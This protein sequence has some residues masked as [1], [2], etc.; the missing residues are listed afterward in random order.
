MK[1]GLLLLVSALFTFALSA[2]VVVFTENFESPS[3][4]DS[5]TSTTGAGGVKHWDIS[6]K[7]SVSGSNSDSARVG[8]ASTY[9]LTTD[10]FNTVGNTYVLLEF[11]QICKITFFDQAEVEVSGDSGQTWNKLTDVHYL[12]GASFAG[13]GSRFAESSYGS[14]WAPN[15]PVDPLP[16]WWKGELFDISAFAASATHAAVRFKL[17]DGGPPGP[18]NRYG[19]LIDDIKVTAALSELQP[20]N[21]ISFTPVLT[22]NIFDTGPFN[23]TAEITDA[24]GIQRAFIPYTINGIADTV[25]LVNTSGNNWSGS[26]PAVTH[27]DDVCYR[28]VVIDNSLSHNVA[29]SPQ[30]GKHCFTASTEEAAL[31]AIN[32]PSTACGLGMEEVE[33]RIKNTGMTTIAGDLWASYWISGTTDTVT[34]YI[35]DTILVNQVLDY[36]FDSLIDVSAP[37]GNVTYQ[38]KT[39]ID[40]LGDPVATNNSQTKTFISGFVPPEAPVLTDTINYATKATLITTITGAQINWYLDSLGTQ[41]IH[42]GDTFI[43]PT[44]FSDTVFYRNATSIGSLP[45]SSSP[46]PYFV[47]VGDKPPYDAAITEVSKPKSAINMLPQEEVVATV[48]NF[49]GD[50]ISNFPITYTINTGTPVVESINDTLNPGDSLVYTFNAYADLSTPGSYEFKVWVSLPGDTTYLNDTITKMVVHSIPNFCQSYAVNAATG[51][52]IGNVYFSN[53]NNGSASPPTNNPTAINGYTDYTTSAPSVQLAIGLSFNFSVTRIMEGNLANSKAGVKLF[54]DY[55][56]SGTYDEATETAFAG[57]INHY[58]YQTGGMITIPNWVNPGVTQMRVVLQETS[59]F[60][61]VHACGVYGIGETEDYTVVM[62][63]QIP[64]D[65]GVSAIITPGALV[66]EASAQ[67]VNVAVKNYGLDTL[68]SFDVIYDHNNNPSVTETWTGTLVP[69]GT[70]LFQFTTPLTVAGGPNTICAYTDVDF[71]SNLG[72]NSFCKSFY[73][74]PLQN[75]EAVELVDPDVE[76]CFVGNE[77][78]TIAIKNVGLDTIN[79][80]LDASYY[81][82]GQAGST[83]TETVNATILPNQT[84]NYTFNQ[85]VD[86][87]A[88]TNDT[89]WEVVGYTTLAGDFENDNDTTGTSVE[90]LYSPPDPIVTN[91]TIPYATSATLTASS[92]D[93][94][95]WYET[96]TAVDEL[97]SGPSY[98]TPVLYGQEVYWVEAQTDGGATSVS[99]GNGTSLTSYIPCYGFYDYGWSA[100][101][102]TAAE[103]NTKGDID[104]IGYYV[105]NS[106]NNYTM[107]NQKIY[108]AHTTASSFSSTAKP[109]PNTMT[110]VYSGDITWAGPAL[111]EIALDNSFNYNGNDNL[112]V[113]YENH[114]GNYSSGYP[115]F[116]YA[117]TSGNMAKYDYQDNSFPTGSGS[118]STNRP[119]IKFMGSG[120]GC[121]SNRMPDTVF[122]TG[123]PQYDGAL[124]E[125][126]DPTSG[127]NL[128]PAEPVTVKVRN[129]GVQPISNFSVSYQIN[130]GSIKT[131]TISVTLQQ[132]DTLDY[133]FITPANLEFYG[134]YQFK[135]WISVANDAMG[136]NDTLYKTVKNLPPEYCPSYSTTPGSYEDIGNVTLGNLNNG[137]PNPTTSNPNAT[138]GYT[139]WTNLTPAML[140]PT[141]N[142]PISISAISSSSVYSSSVSVKAYIDY[143]RDGTFDPFTENAFSGT[144]SSSSPTATGTVSVPV[145]ATPG[146]TVMR[147]V[148]DRYGS[149]APCGT[150]TYGETEDYLVLIIPMIPNDAGVTEILSP[151]NLGTAG[152]QVDVTVKIQNFGTNTL[153][154]VDILYDVNGGTPKSYTYLMPLAPQATAIVNLPQ[155]TLTQGNNHICAYTV[156]PGDS[157][158]FNDGRCL[159]DYA[160]F[161]SDLPYSNRFDQPAEEFWPDSIP[162]QWERG[163]PTGMVLNSAKSNPNVWGIAIDGPYDHNGSNFLYTPKFN[164]LVTGIDS[165][166][167]W[168]KMDANPGDGGAIQYLSMLGWKLLG[169]QNDP[170]AQNWYNSNMNLW[171]GNGGSNAWMHSAYSL[172]TVYDMAEP[173]QF[174]Y[175]FF[176]TQENNNDYE[177]WIIDN[178]EISIPVIPRDAGVIEILGPPSPTVIGT[179]I[180]VEVRF[181]NFGSDTLYT[182]PLQYKVNGATVNTGLWTGVLPPDSTAEY[183]FGPLPCPL[184]DYTLC[185]LTTLSGD[186][187]G[188]NNTS[189]DTF[190][191]LQPNF[192]LTVPTIVSPQTPTIHGE[193]AEVSVWVR[194]QGLQAVDYFDIKYSVADSVIS[195]ESWQDVANPLQPGDSMLFTF[196]KQYKHDY[197]GFYYMCVEVTVAGDGYPWNDEKCTILE[198]LYT[199]ITESG[200]EG[201]TMGQNIPNPAG[202][203]TVIPFSLPS[204]GQYQFTIVNYLGQPV[205]SV[206][207]EA[208][209]GLHQIEVDASRFTP[210]VYFYYMEFEGYRLLRK[211]IVH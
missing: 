2:Q 160:E 208:G 79:G 51:S 134:T 14:L 194:N 24:S 47:D 38:L 9:Y 15:N 207:D 149:A 109:D 65:G 30:I 159:D 191:V 177:G 188:Y 105:G 143:N 16:S 178:F 27:L 138:Q 182:V 168:H 12:G 78:V 193:S 145:N 87:T 174:R 74:D 118:M 157:N 205:F 137:N 129:Y 135:A 150:Y 125:I 4:D 197:I 82:K 56:R 18:Q 95:F 89:I 209:A 45:C 128:S 198:E 196:T 98:T 13:L 5:V 53:L 44:L 84:Y 154:N 54:I 161:T 180:I 63:P 97:A 201:Y 70:T 25:D 210:G 112:L 101:I 80:G 20:P 33:I 77:Q 155:H 34:E 94:I 99:I 211:M 88:Y 206:S 23:F 166:T 110:E 58:T 36:T 190:T 75:A 187:N 200:L 102:Y 104:S 71:D 148:M 132:N 64:F 8:S 122:V 114:D 22:G 37:N 81:V 202:D 164:H 111:Q 76:G 66:P 127:T 115:R 156:V 183:T 60:N 39:K 91:D 126:I 184:T 179:D 93:S 35:P 204:Y 106:V 141:V 59:N 1:K 144:V 72:N 11:N 49:G 120:G 123:I 203:V 130:A 131:D 90:S 124:L 172:N 42:T 199:E 28:L 29:V 171:T 26:I 167:F 147:V 113:Y 6:N 139:N 10:F 153:N 195:E 61:N 181:E 142:Y 17:S 103:L 100:C 69:G 169:S 185:A 107:P 31:L 85:L 170:K 162:N 152:D 48:V 43:T 136:T 96:Q 140:S 175:I 19:W 55:D 116:S 3:L 92:P 189:C 176:T 192:D 173:T 186:I 165:I 52:D 46:R 21:I 158:T 7:Y 146:T 119:N 57:T 73:G 50:T 41:L 133:T 32:S 108:L 163:I 67:T 62:Y 121:P 117:S 86:L 40:L 151:G 68:T 83:V